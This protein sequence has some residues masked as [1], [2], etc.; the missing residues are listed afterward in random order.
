MPQ[1]AAT[2]EM[3]EA[4]QKV[5]ALFKQIN[6][7]RESFSIFFNEIK[8]LNIYNAR[9]QSLDTRRKNMMKSLKSMGIDNLDTRPLDRHLQ[10]REGHPVS[11]VNI[12]IDQR[13]ERQAVSLVRSALFA[14]ECDKSNFHARRCEKTGICSV[15]A[16]AY[17]EVDFSS[18]ISKS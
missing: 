17:A 11:P 13:Q 4:G 2:Q 15:E 7:V 16:P 9:M 12:L 5:A 14:D 18:L 3:G 6:S 10:V 1:S 8:T